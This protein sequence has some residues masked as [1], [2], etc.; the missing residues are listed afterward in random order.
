MKNY[1]NI[2]FKIDG[3]LTRLEY[4]LFGLL[5]LILFIVF[6]FSFRFYLI[7]T[8][9]TI[10]I[11]WIVSVASI[12]RGRDSGLNALVTLILFFLVPSVVLNFH[13]FTFDSFEYFALSF[14]LFLTVVPS[15]KKEIK[16]ISIGESIV[17]K[18]LISLYLATLFIVPLVVPQRTCG[19]GLPLEGLRCI[20]MGGVANALELF[21][22]DNGVYPTQREG[23]DALIQNPNFE[24]Y[25]NYAR[26]AYL[27]KMPHDYSG[28]FLIYKYYKN[29]KKFE[30]ISFREDEN[31]D[32]IYYP[33]C[34]EE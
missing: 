29:E 5:P 8:L 18:I 23:L 16:K 34:I 31:K 21:K 7:N 4:L 20:Q 1:L 6:V 26:D 2:L 10:H 28:K 13:L 14:I 25:P 15:S 32:M 33:E 11:I 30:L 22:L 17:L 9:L 19:G 24:K 3:R 27:K 12:K